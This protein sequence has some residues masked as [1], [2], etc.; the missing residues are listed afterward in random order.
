VDKG[1]RGA[2]DAKRQSLVAAGEKGATGAAS[3]TS[4][5]TGDRGWQIGGVGGADS[6]GGERG[7]RDAAEGGEW[8]QDEGGMEERVP[9]DGRGA[10]WREGTWPSPGESEAVGVGGGL[11]TPAKVWMPSFLPA[12]T[13]NILPWD[14]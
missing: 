3:S 12:P 2:S 1:K 14:R 4:S 10:D 9:R 6:D 11:V 8:S 5:D 7:E 13:R